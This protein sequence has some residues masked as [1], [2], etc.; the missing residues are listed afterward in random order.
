MRGRARPDAA[1]LE[2]GRDL[3]DEALADAKLHLRRVGD[4][5]DYV[6]VRAL[7]ARLCDEGLETRADL[8][9]RKVARSR[10]ELDPQRHG[11]LAAVAQLED[12]AARD[13]AVVH[14]VEDAHLVEVEHHLEL[15]RR[16][17]LDA[18]VAAVDLGE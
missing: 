18:L 7:V 8:A 15:G 6:P 5:L 16:H 12:G 10:D 4:H 3:H 11:A 17:H 13:G 2:S 9:R 1:A 14:E